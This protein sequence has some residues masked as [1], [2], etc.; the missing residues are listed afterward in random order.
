MSFVGLPPITLP[1]ELLKRWLFLF[2]DVG[3]AWGNDG[4]NPPRGDKFIPDVGGG[5]IPGPMDCGRSPTPII[6][7]AGDNGGRPGGIPG[8]GT[9]PGGLGRKDEAGDGGNLA[10]LEVT[11]DE[12]DGVMTVEDI[13]DNPVWMKNM[14]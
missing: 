3:E 9:I 8:G 13:E 11:I 14:C 12:E 10:L 1:P 7:I 4:D 5:R 2:G 6:A